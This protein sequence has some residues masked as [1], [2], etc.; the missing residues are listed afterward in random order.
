M[1]NKLEIKYVARDEAWLDGGE[2]AV[3]LE[4][5]VR[6]FVAEVE[7]YPSVK[8]ILDEFVSLY[9]ENEDTLFSR[10]AIAFAAESFGAFLDAHGFEMSP[11][12]E[13]YYVNYTL[14]ACCEKTHPS[15][16]RLDG[17]EA[18]DDL[19]ETDI[20]G[21]ISDGY[22]AYAAVVD[23]KIAALA[24]T[25]EPIDTD[26]PKTVEIGVDTAEEYRKR[27]LGKACVLALVSELSRLGHTAM[28]ECAS[29]NTAS[30]RLAESVG[31]QIAYKKYY[32]VGFAE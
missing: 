8:D 2:V 32:A 7:Y 19:T 27:G 15:V 18:Y 1:S 21:L 31:G 13:D 29:G 9:G 10:E 16:C 11:D 12:S 6:D 23:N 20:G 4:I 25:G 26:T 28:Y 5:T 30:I 24:N 14:P 22:I 3:P 17:T